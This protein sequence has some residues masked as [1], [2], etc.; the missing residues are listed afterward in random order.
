MNKIFFQMVHLVLFF[1]FV[2]IIPSVLILLFMWTDRTLDFWCTY[3]SGNVVDVPFWLSAIATLVGNG[4]MLG[5]NIISEIV[6]LCI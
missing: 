4:V 5:L 6:R 1:F 2:L 3:I